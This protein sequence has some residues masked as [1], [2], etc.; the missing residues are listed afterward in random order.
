MRAK[1]LRITAASD[2]AKQKQQQDLELEFA[3][4]QNELEI[5]KARE[6]AQTE[7]ERIQRMVSAI[8]RQTLV[9][10]AQAGPEMQAKLLGGLGLKGYL[11]TDGKTPV[12]LFNTAQGMLGGQTTETKS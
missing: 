10:I 4:R 6:L 11:I 7:V 5:V 12:N 1:A 8:G 9:S 2:L 3:K